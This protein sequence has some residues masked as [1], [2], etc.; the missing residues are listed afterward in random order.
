MGGLVTYS[1]SQLLSAAAFSLT[2][3]VAATGRTASTGITLAVAE[4]RKLDHVTLKASGN[5]T[6]TVSLTLNSAKGS[7]YDI[8]LDSNA[9]VAETAAYQYVPLSPIY[10]GPG[11]NLTLSCTFANTPAVTVSGAIVCEE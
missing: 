10:L 8:L 9:Y 5:I 6:E 7:A 4:R 2:T 1:G 3:N 11:D